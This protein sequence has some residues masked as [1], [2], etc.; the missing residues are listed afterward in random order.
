MSDIHSIIQRYFKGQTSEEENLELHQWAQLSPENEKQLFAEKDIWDT[1][2]FHSN[3]KNYEID[4]E[5]ELVK[6]R[7]PVDWAA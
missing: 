2:G 5:L 3:L 1:F 7:A 4:P 6:A